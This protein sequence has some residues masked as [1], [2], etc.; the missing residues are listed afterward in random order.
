[1]AAPL[2]TR[3][4]RKEAR[5]RRLLSA[6]LLI[7]SERGYNDTSV[8]QVVAQA[9]TS[10]TTFYE[11]FDSKED[12]VRDLLAREGGSL[13]HAV[14]SAA[15]QGADHRDRMRRGITAFVVGLGDEGVAEAWTQSM[16]RGWRRHHDAIGTLD[17]RELVGL[18]AATWRAHIFAKSTS[19]KSRN[20]MVRSMAKSGA[21]ICSTKPCRTMASYSTCSARPRAA[22]YAS[23]VS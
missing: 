13:I 4:E 20:I 5:R 8:D 6:A 7:M 11:F 15:A 22:R 14:T 3:Q 10:K 12:C 19:D 9:R 21:S 23:S 17:R 1:L 16:G 2:A 18:L